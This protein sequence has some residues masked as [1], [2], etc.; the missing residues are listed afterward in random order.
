MLGQPENT[1][2]DSPVLTDTHEWRTN[3]SE[4]M[5]SISHTTRIGVP[6]YSV[7]QEMHKGEITMWMSRGQNRS[8]PP[9]QCRRWVTASSSHWPRDGW[10][11]ELAGHGPLT[12]QCIPIAL[13]CQ[14]CCRRWEHLSC[15]TPLPEI[16]SKQQAVSY[17]SWEQLF[18]LTLN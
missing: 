7:L 17:C 10:D 16:R 4:N 18:V 14:E 11:A 13:T 12:Q 9:A 8:S 1:S 15:Q 2:S 6:D 5:V 3:A